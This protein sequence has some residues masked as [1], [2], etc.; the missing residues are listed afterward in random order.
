MCHSYDIRHAILGCNYFPEVPACNISLLA[1]DNLSGLAS[2]IINFV[3]FNHP[4]LL[5]QT[6][7]KNIK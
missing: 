7:H 3:Q 5:N 2:Q 4:S 1:V 6:H